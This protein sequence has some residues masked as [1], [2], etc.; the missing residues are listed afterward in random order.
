MARGIWDYE[1][2]EGY[3]AGDDL[4]GYRVEASDGRIGKVDKHSEEV[5]Q[6]HLVVDTGPWIFGR[7]VLV[8]AGT[9]N[10]IDHDDR[11]VWLDRSM[12]DVRNSPEFDPDAHGDSSDY[13]QALGAY[14]FGT[15]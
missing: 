13:H 10:R 4:T 2:A 12:E 6:A 15:A 7:T 1:S 9:I 11:S 8:P 14:Y 3:N 5:G